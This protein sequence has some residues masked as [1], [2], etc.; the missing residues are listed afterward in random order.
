MRPL[1]YLQNPI[2]H[3]LQCFRSNGFFNYT[4]LLLSQSLHAEK[5][6]LKADQILPDF[7][8]RLP[9]YPFHHLMSGMEFVF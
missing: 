4:I 6:D 5:D 1:L 9:E 8:L 7:L 2:G 3:D